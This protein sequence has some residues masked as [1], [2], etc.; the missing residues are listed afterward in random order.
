MAKVGRPKKT[1]DYVT[2]EKLASMMATQ[3]EIATYLDISSRT[4]QR[5]EEFCRVYKKGLDNGKM[6]LRRKQFLLADKNATMSIWLGK[7]YLNQRDRHEVEHSG[8]IADKYEKMSDDE[9]NKELKK[10]AENDTTTK[11]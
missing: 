1:I 4:L 9:L 7:Q 8:Y 3:E 6:S 10:Y 11:N 2:V 5:D